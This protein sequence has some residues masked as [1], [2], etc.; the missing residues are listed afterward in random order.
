GLAPLLEQGEA[1]LGHPDGGVDLGGIDGL[2]IAI[3]IAVAVGGTLAAWRLFAVE[4]GLLRVAGRPSL[5]T[6]LSNRL[7]FL[8]RASANKW[9]FD[10]IHN[11]LFV[12]IGGRLA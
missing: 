5:V 10:D 12:V 2:L 1:R 11:L 6:Q 8:Y 9:W 4:I 3:S 7:W